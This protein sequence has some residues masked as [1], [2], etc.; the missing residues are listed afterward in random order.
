MKD[1][2]LPA[3]SCS[4]LLCAL[5]LFAAGCKNDP[6]KEPE[7]P[8][9]EEQRAPQ[10]LNGNAG[11]PAWEVTKDYDM[12]S[13]MTAVVKADLLASYPDLA[14]D[15][16]LEDD[17]LLAAFSGETCLGVASPQDGLFFLY[18]GA[19]V[20]GN[21]SSITLRYYST[22]YKNIFVA[23]DEFSFVNDAH[24]GTVANPVVPKLV[25]VK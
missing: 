1:M 10:T 25:V 7:S 23:T 4:I 24:L 22:H 8:Q 3:K 5:L 13:S 11:K 9:Q 19:P 12:T 15:F 16:A 21:P 6:E 17:D 20:T 18:I 2:T 14:K